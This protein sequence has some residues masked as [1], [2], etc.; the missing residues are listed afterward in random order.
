M[1]SP[2]AASVPSG[3]SWSCP[4]TA[5]TTA[6]WPGRRI[7]AGRAAGASATGRRSA[8]RSGS[9]RRLF[10]LG[11]QEAATLAEV[12]DAFLRFAQS[13]APWPLDGLAS[14]DLVEKA[15]NVFVAGLFPDIVKRRFVRTP[16]RS[17]EGRR[18]GRKTAQRLT[19][20]EESPRM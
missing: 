7:A 10:L 8:S 2:G 16:P 3:R 6:C 20:C 1:C 18:G 19:A 13:Y 14:P 12:E 4:V 5:S 11:V 15:R 9:V 17:R